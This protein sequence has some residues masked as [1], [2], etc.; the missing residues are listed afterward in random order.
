MNPNE[1]RDVVCEMQDRDSEEEEKRESL[2]L[3]VRFQI[4]PQAEVVR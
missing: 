2:G 3:L 4:L 1:S